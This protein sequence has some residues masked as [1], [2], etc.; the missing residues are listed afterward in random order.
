MCGRVVFK[1][2][3][4]GF[5][6]IIESGHYQIVGRKDFIIHP[7]IRNAISFHNRMHRRSNLFALLHFWVSGKNIPHII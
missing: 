5:R 6:P 2:K 7:L 4:G 1:I 3:M